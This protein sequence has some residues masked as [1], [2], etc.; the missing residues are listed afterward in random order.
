[1]RYPNDGTPTR[2]PICYVA[3]MQTLDTCRPHRG[4]AVTALVHCP[5][6]KTVLSFDA[7]G[8]VAVTLETQCVFRPLRVRR[9]PKVGSTVIIQTLNPNSNPHTRPNPNPSLNL[10]PTPNSKRDANPNP[11]P[12]PEP[13]LNPEHNPTTRMEEWL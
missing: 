12:K 6:T 2:R 10:N 7:H 13:D 4:V 11:D 8:T 3:F 1:M 5:T 9:R